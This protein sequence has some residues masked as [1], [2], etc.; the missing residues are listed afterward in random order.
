MWFLVISGRAVRLWAG[1]GPWGPRKSGGGPESEPEQVAR[2]R[3]RRSKA[4][5]FQRPS[6]SWDT[7]GVSEPVAMEMRLRGWG[8]D[9]VSTFAYICGEG[10]QISKKNEFKWQ[11]SFGFWPQ[12]MGDVSFGAHV[13][14]QNVL[15][16]LGNLAYL[17]YLGKCCVLIAISAGS[18]LE[19]QP[20]R[21]KSICCVSGK[22]T[23][24][25]MT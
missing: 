23:P 13:T 7:R 14:L 18:S 25:W 12:L 9:A 15:L 20:V 21:G 5:H 3:P 4:A 22:G 11:V 24:Y 6:W 1:H 10:E 17:I 8:S 16:P 2:P 19:T